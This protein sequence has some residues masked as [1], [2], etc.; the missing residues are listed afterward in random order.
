MVEKTCIKV[1]V[2]AVLAAD[3][4]MLPSGLEVADLATLFFWGFSNKSVFGS[5]ETPKVDF[6]LRISNDFNQFHSTWFCKF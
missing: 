6:S 4:T 3:S 1:A 2:I 5:H